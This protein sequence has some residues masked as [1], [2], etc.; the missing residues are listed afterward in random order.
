MNTKIMEG[1]F[2][3]VCIAIFVSCVDVVFG[4]NAEKK[5]LSDEAIKLIDILGNE[6]LVYLDALW[7]SSSLI[8]DKKIP[9]SKVS[10]EVIEKSVYWIKTAVKKE[11]LPEDLQNRLITLKDFKKWEKR[12]KQG[13][14]FSQ[15]VGDYIIAEY[16]IRGYKINIQENGQ[17]LSLLV[18]LPDTTDISLDPQDFIPAG[19]AELL[20]YF[21]W[22]R[23]HLRGSG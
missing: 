1:V 3:I 8:E 17:S 6:K 22:V 9:K 19:R 20:R 5:L 11:W 23:C 12:N 7:P 13:I 2:I 21:I 14:V 4:G 18:V 16:E 15:W 10:H